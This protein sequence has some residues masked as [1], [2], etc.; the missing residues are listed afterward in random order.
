MIDLFSQL[1]GPYPF[2]VYGAVVHDLDLGFALETQTLSVFGRRTGER[3]VAHELA[4]QWFGNSVSLSRWQDIWLNEG[5]ATYAE[6]LWLEHLEGRE[7]LDEAIERTYRRVAPGEQVFEID[8]ADLVE[9]LNSLELNDALL[10]PLKLKAALEALFSNTLSESDL[11]ALIK[12][13]PLDGLP[14]S[15]FPAL[16]DEINFEQV[17]LSTEQLQTLFRAIGQPERANRVGRGGTIV[18][19]GKPTAGQL[20]NQGVYQRGGLTLY[21]LRLAVG[22]AAFF[23]ILRTYTARFANGN[24]TTA[25]FM[26][27]AEDVSGQELDRFFESWLYAEEI[28]DLPELGLYRKDH[29]FEKSP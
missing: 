10:P 18:P 22:D 29:T 20:F 16:L 9:G 4:H 21:A 24:A 14:G 11:Q 6:L 1:F 26:A 25:D 3:V 15:D 5:F 23:E 28:P 7:A 27:V 8:K 13:L 12:D 19:P 17:R 2:E